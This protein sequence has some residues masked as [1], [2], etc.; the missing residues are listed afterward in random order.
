MDKNIT[1]LP[2]YPALKKLASSL[3]QQDNTYH[4]AAVMVGAGFSR[5]AATT[6]DTRKKLP[7]WSD[8][9]QTLSTE[10]K[11]WSS[12]PLRLAEEYCAFFG[13]QSLHD[14][15]KKEVNDVA[16]SPSQLHHNLLN[17]PWS[18]VL[19]TNWDTLLE[20]ASIE[21]HSRVYSI[22]NKQGDLS[23]SRSPRIVKLHGTIDITNE[24][25]FTQED[26]RRYP[27]SYAAFVNF[28]R[29]V[30]IENELCLLGF[31]GEDPNFLQWAGWVRDNLTT[32]SRRIYLVG[33]LNLKGPK[34]KYLESINV[35]PIDL[36]DLVSEFDDHDTKH[37]EVTK[38]FLQFL[39]E[40]KPAP[41]W[42]WQPTSL[43]P[44]SMNEDERRKI[45]DLAYGAR[46]MEEQLTLLSQD[47]E[48]YPGW[49][50]CPLLIRRELEAQISH[51]LPR[52]EHLPL[53]SASSRESLLYEIVWRLEKTFEIPPPWMAEELLKV[54]DPT[55]P[56]SLGKKQQLE[57][58]LFLLKSTRWMASEESEKFIKAT[59]MI[60]ENGI[61]FWPESRNELIYYQALI[62]RDAFDYSALEKQT[63]EI[64][65][66]SAIWKLR[67]A[68]LLAELGKFEQGEK[69]I[70]DAHRDLLGQYR[71]NQNSMFILSQLAWAK[72]LL[73]GTDPWSA[74]ND[75]GDYEQKKCSPWEHIE[76]IR[77]RINKSVEEQ[78]K[79][80]AIEPSF[81]AGIY[82]DNTN[83]VAI[84]YEL[85]PLPLLEGLC[86]A[87][88]IPLRW[89]FTGL[90]TD[91][92]GRLTE[93]ED[94]SHLQRLTLAVR[95]ANSDDC[96][97]I[98]TVFSRIGMACLPQHDADTLLNRCAPAI[99][100]WSEK[101]IRD[102]GCDRGHVLTR[103]RVFI[104]VLA[105]ISV[106]ATPEQAI[107]HFRLA[108]SLCNNP[109]FRHMWL[110]DA[111]RHLF[112][113]SLKS[114]PESEHYS[115]LSD[116]LGV[117]LA[118]EI[119]IN[120]S[121]EWINPIIHSP[122]KRLQNPEID[123]RIDAII[124]QIEFNS[125]ISGP[126]LE[127][128]LP[129]ISSGFLT[130]DE[131]IKIQKKVWGDKLD[132][133]MLP[134]TG[135]YPYVLL[136]I[137]SP[138][139]IAVKTHLREYLFDVDRENLI[140]LSR[141]ANIIYVALSEGSK[142][143]PNSVQATDLFNKMMLWRPQ[144]KEND[145]LGFS[146]QSDEQITRMVGNALSKSV[147][148]SLPKS[149]LTEC[150]FHKLYDF[151]REYHLPV[152]LVA[153]PR[154]ICEGSVTPS[155]L[156]K[157]IRKELQSSDPNSIA[158]ASYALLAWREQTQLP[159]ID[160]L[161]TRLIMIIE[162]GRMTGLQALIWTANQMYLK[163]F[164]DTDSIAS[165]IDSLPLIFDNASYS[166]VIPH[167]RESVS[168]SFVRAACVKLAS[169]IL[170]RSDSQHVELKRIID[171]SMEDALPEVRYAHMAK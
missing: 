21:L 92:A 114:I 122:G 147:V 121:R 67:K 98:N 136:K 162:S 151:G 106:R 66:I 74:K 26:Y 139:P 15:I 81:E 118:S 79:Q 86:A 34:R 30:F 78:K 38:I 128:L 2:D 10:L 143:L 59:L 43:R 97:V 154:F 19:T 3:W 9:S 124:D 41:T 55:F 57:I 140:E 25:I 89:K 65:G 166:N 101:L 120:N 76:Y 152:V 45:K 169:D 115:V 145:I 46:M 49:L 35:S 32:N 156:E 125:P 133:Q 60:L 116:A 18:E 13:K 90:L 1:S 22:V 103:L 100:F 159:I 72:W 8:F 155:I 24:L 135:L 158:H 107:N 153:L 119:D 14:L 39:E 132:I 91:I 56:C 68:A 31:S 40:S 61:K 134:I 44:V 33:A 48:T 108:C 165:L 130:Q 164:L 5:S 28:A 109:E 161:I 83:R 138:D 63:D 99:D 77:K 70:A 47:R 113:F 7:L 160:K 87:A 150:N 16:W 171:E 84:S 53:M 149:A 11:S 142:E 117:P 54:C 123:R 6:G 51:P 168:V 58:A 163:D 137:P 12:D 105:R 131:L 94:L 104:E 50:I 64:E 85:H 80:R 111:L 52:Q 17:L 112:D 71:H 69:Y 93:M 126:A 167:S 110:N 88:G 82:K 37:L 42:E 36:S 148:P 20:R 170:H 96:E 62:S 146:Q 144:V 4:G 127:R 29:Q 95:T 157:I 27:Q 75:Y 73:R 141:L 129:L 23:S 102:T